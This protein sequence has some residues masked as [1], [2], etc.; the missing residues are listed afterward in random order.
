[1]KHTT[2][3]LALAALLAPGAAHADDKAQK[4]LEHQV[5][6]A[7]L[8]VNM[9]LPERAKETLVELVKTEPGKSDALTWLALSKAN[10]ALK[11]LDDAGEALNRAEGLGVEQRLDEK[12]WAKSYYEE[13]E[14][15]VGGVRIRDAQCEN[16]KFRARLAVPMVNRKKRAL[17]EALDGWRTKELERRTDR[18]FYLPAGQFMLGETKVKIIPGQETSVTAKEIGAEC[19]ALPQAVATAGGP[20]GGGVT[21]TAPPS[22]GGQQGGFLESNWLWVVLGAVAVAGGATTVAVVATRD[23]GPE[24]FRQVF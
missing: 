20:G 1:M 6:Q 23:N 24:R 21:G 3:A 14:E 10:Y 12:S 11:A 4:R 8:Y 16:V 2:A 22:G 9:K 5:E 19:T 7:M 18:P 15:L 13:I 17:L